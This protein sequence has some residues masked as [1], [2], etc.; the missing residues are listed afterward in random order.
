MQLRTAV[1]QPTYC[2]SS[3]CILVAVMSHCDV[4]MPMP[5]FVS[6]RSLL[7]EQDAASLSTKGFHQSLQE[8]QRQV[9]ACS[10]CGSGL[11]LLVLMYPSLAG[12]VVVRAE[13]VA[14]QIRILAPASAGVSKQFAADAL[15]A[16]PFVE[17]DWTGSG[18]IEF[19]SQR[20]ERRSYEFSEHKV[21]KAGATEAT[22]E[23]VASSRI[24][25]TKEFLNDHSRGRRWLFAGTSGRL[26]NC[27][28][29][30]LLV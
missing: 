12:V 13:G 11:V 20:D 29:E 2:F 16:E 17:Q 8:A 7:S 22:F 19:R 23:G 3:T 24:E 9:P 4:P 14:R 21:Q 28:A 1:C 15:Y 25:I 18:R 5:V 6:C 26:A 10:F 27:I 30:S